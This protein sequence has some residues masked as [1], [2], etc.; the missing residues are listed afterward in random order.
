MT[1]NCKMINIQF[2]ITIEM[3]DV[4]I[5]GHVVYSIH[6]RKRCVDVSIY[7][8]TVS[9]ATETESNRQNMMHQLKQQLLRLKSLT[10]YYLNNNQ[11]PFSED[12]SKHS[13]QS[14]SSMIMG[15]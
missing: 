11:Y 15:G 9:V 8:A 2:G 6:W 10:R 4:T 14:H 13:R 3:I 7:E 5:L 12:A 1:P